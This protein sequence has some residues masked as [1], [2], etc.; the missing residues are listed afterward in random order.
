MAQ[1]MRK[2]RTRPKPYVLDNF[3]GLDPGGGEGGFTSLVNFRIVG[4]HLEKRCGSRL[5]ESY[6]ADIRG[7]W[8]GDFDGRPALFCVAGNALYMGTGDERRTL[9]NIGTSSGR[10]CIFFY[11]GRL[12]I[13]DGA[14]FYYWD[15][16]SLGIVEGYV[17]LISIGSA[18]T[19]GTPYYDRNRLNNRVIIRLNDMTSGKEYALSGDIASVEKAVWRNIETPVT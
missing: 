17:P 11:H 13:L 19:S 8:Y 6:P 9:A 12:Y 18:G 3:G 15:G 5:L 14:E 1:L 2:R 4:G 10:V 16:T 7:L